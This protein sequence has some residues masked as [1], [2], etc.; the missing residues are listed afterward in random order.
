MKRQLSLLLYFLFVFPISGCNTNSSSSLSNNQPSF[1]ILNFSLSTSDSVITGMFQ[2]LYERA[3]SATELSRWVT[4]IDSQGFSAQDIRAY[5]ATTNESRTNID[6]I[7]QIA[8]KRPATDAEAYSRMSELINGASLADIR[9]KI[10]G[11]ISPA[12][13]PATTTTT[14]T[15]TTAPSVPQGTPEQIIA[16]TYLNIF[17]YNIPT[18][19]A[20]YVAQLR[21]GAYSIEKVRYELAFTGRAQIIVRDLYLSIK[22][23]Y[24]SAEQ[25]SSY[26]KLLSGGYTL[27][28]VKANISGTT[29]AP[30]PDRAPASIPPPTTEPAPAPA[31]EPT[32]IYTNTTEGKIKSMFQDLFERAPST[33]ELSRWVAA[34]DTQG[35]SLQ[36]IRAYLAT[37]NESSNNINILFQQV[38]KRNASDAEA[39]NYM[40]KLINGQTLNDVRLA[41]T[42]TSQ[43]A[44][45]PTPTTTSTEPAPTTTA[46]VV[47]APPPVFSGVGLLPNQPQ[48]FTQLVHHN[49]SSKT[50]PGCY[51]YY[52][53]G[54][55]ILMNDSSEPTSPSGIVRMIKPAYSTVG[56]TVLECFH[57]PRSE[58]YYEFT[59]RPSSP[60]GGYNNGA[61][62][63]VFFTSDKPNA[64]GLWG[65]HFYGSNNGGRVVDIFLQAA[66][67]NNC[68]IP[69][70]Y[71]DCADS[72]SLVFLPN[73][74]G[75]AVLEGQWHR[76]EVY[77]R[78]STTTTS[79]DGIIMVW[80]DN[81]LRIKNT[82]VNMPPYNWRSIEVNHTWDG[83][84][85]MRNPAVASTVAPND[86]RPYDDYHDFGDFFAS[87]R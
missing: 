37:T 44:P 22:G 21:S 9:A 65:S 73:V 10:T 80:V 41:I 50:G 32:P 3:P 54:G 69:N 61:N 78:R 84:C 64:V 16:Q 12:P 77:F 17:G 24:P 51:D 87:G 81:S 63:L 26:Q 5:L 30:Q 20:Y 1:R 49:F 59:W 8:Y 27:T 36:D 55:A 42:G 75:A 15:T 35:F 74:N 85:S 56:G 33:T 83:Q 25:V 29:L 13:A 14:T 68:H 19:E 82:N 60:F 71:G 45:A 48:G 7:Y 23:S 31:P 11:I 40:T 70:A 39:N 38:Y 67:V 46:P 4:A 62:K 57:D 52:P 53:Q 76:V 72:A 86:C 43:S 18:E 2:S 66:N 79:Q 6:K 58:I 34:I 47:S 28:D